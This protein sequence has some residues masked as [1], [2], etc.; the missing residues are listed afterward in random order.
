MTRCE[1]VCRALPGCEPCASEHQAAP[2]G[3]RVIGA[4]DGW[5]IT[6]PALDAELARIDRTLRRQHAED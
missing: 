2:D 3:S 4:M 1:E 5:T 6:V